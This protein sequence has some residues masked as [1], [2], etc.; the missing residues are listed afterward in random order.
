MKGVYDEI[1]Y[2]GCGRLFNK[3]AI[4]VISHNHIVFIAYYRSIN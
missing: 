1:V 3:I 4:V 2:G